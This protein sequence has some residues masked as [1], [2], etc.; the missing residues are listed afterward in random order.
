MDVS[1]RALE[2]AKK[3]LQ[4]DRLSVSGRDRV[5]LIHGA[6][7]SPDNRLALRCGGGGGDHRASRRGTAHRF[8]ASAL[9]TRQT[10]DNSADGT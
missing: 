10:D 3:R 8:R 4:L 9:R 2:I 7:T 6:L 5:R 1:Y